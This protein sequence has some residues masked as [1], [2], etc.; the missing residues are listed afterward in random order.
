[1]Q[2][3]TLG[4]RLICVQRVFAAIAYCIEIFFSS[5]LCMH[6]YLVMCAPLDSLC[7]A[8]TL[9]LE[10]CED[11]LLHLGRSLLGDLTRRDDVLNAIIDM[12]V[13]DADKVYLRRENTI[14]TTTAAVP[15]ATTPDHDMVFGGTELTDV[16]GEQAIGGEVVYVDKKLLSIHGGLLTIRIVRHLHKFYDVTVYD[17]DSPDHLGYN[18]HFPMAPMGGTPFALFAEHVTIN[19]TPLFIALEEHA[20]PHAFT[21][22]ISTVNSNKNGDNAFNVRIADDIVFPLV[23]SSHKWAFAELTTRLVST[24]PIIDFAALTAHVV[25]SGLTLRMDANGE[26]WSPFREHTRGRELFS[27]PDGEKKKIAV[28]RVAHHTPYDGDEGTRKTLLLQGELDVQDGSDEEV[29]KLQVRIWQAP[30]TLLT[31]SLNMKN[32]GTT[33][34]DA[35]Y[36]LALS[37]TTLPTARIFTSLVQLPQKTAPLCVAIMEDL[38]P[39]RVFIVISHPQNPLEC[40]LQ[41]VVLLGENAEDHVSSARSTQQHGKPSEE[42]SVLAEKMCT[43]ATLSTT[44]RWQP[45]REGFA[46]SAALSG[47]GDGGQH[48]DGKQ[49]K[50]RFMMTKKLFGHRMIFTLYQ[51]W[52]SSAEG[53]YFRIVMHDTITKE[54]HYALLCSQASELVAA[55]LLPTNTNSADCGGYSPANNAEGGGRVDS[56]VGKALIDCLYLS[57]FGSKKE[58]QCL[59]EPYELRL[60][61][62]YMGLLQQTAAT[63]TAGHE[64]DNAIVAKMSKTRLGDNIIATGV[65]TL[66]NGRRMLVAVGNETNPQDMLRYS[67]NLRVVVSDE[68]SGKVLLHNDFHEADLERIL[69]VGRHDLLLPTQEDA[70]AQELVKRALAGDDSLM[71]H[72][73]TEER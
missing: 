25:E 68:E 48:G 8:G 2:E 1:M 12:L 63:T 73:D 21:V 53:F 11:D 54:E 65:T 47:K 20:F 35:S 45:S 7:R 23:P 19:D 24:G 13:V 32:S 66:P 52:K 27:L 17:E 50:V 31:L 42:R 46:A 64:N 5:E 58:S 18:V 51:E 3:R 60:C 62:D 4:A 61:D 16:A 10:V 15:A 9:F 72:A 57:E 67:H 70:L 34:E 38:R 39:P 44:V 56:T 69:P 14:H 29:S 26:H 49:P 55:H 6:S 37:D 30:G 33:S 40:L 36:T 28:I 43:L 59:S 41:V 71:L 22:H